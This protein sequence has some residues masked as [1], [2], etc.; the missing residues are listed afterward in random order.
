M[1]L[2]RNGRC[3]RLAG[4]VELVDA[5]DLSAPYKTSGK[6][7][8]RLWFSAENYKQVC[9][10][11]RERAAHPPKPCWKW[12]CEQLHDFVLFMVNT[13]LR[14]DEAARLQ[15]RDVEIVKDAG[16]QETILEISVRGKR[17]VGFCK[18]MPGAV[19]PFGRMC[20]RKRVAEKK[21]KKLMERHRFHQCA[22]ACL[23]PAHRP[24]VSGF[25]GAS[26]QCRAQ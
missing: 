8:H 2:W 23:A 10:A 1:P 18:S 15:F 26:P 11:T 3:G 12:E 24:A 25:A 16:T 6:I 4:V 13:G 9:T 20:K 14:P 21:A 5:P 22:R 17:G 19:L 7:A